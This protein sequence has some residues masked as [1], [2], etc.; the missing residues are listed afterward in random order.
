MCKYINYT[1]MSLG[2]HARERQ[3]HGMME[4]K[5]CNVCGKQLDASREDYLYIEKEWGYF[6]A[7]DGRR[8][9]IRICE[10][11]YDRWM[12]QL[13]IPVDTGDVTELV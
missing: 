4:Q 11:C 13:S 2:E 7:K 8:D 10:S 3:V 1:V 6:S 12:E 9:R 5:L